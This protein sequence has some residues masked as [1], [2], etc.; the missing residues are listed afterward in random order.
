VPFKVVDTD[1][2]IN[3]SPWLAAV[4]RGGLFA[5]GRP[6]CGGTLINVRQKCFIQ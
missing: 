2:G 6:H 3:P 1:A 5:G 4:V